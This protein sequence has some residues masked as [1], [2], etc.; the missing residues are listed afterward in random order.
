MVKERLNRYDNK[1][2]HSEKAN[3]KGIK[4]PQ[5]KGSRRSIGKQSLKNVIDLYKAGYDEYG[6]D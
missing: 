2:K 1:K 6:D 5:S 4:N 3:N